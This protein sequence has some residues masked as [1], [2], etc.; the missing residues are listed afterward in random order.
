NSSVV[1]GLRVG[2]RGQSKTEE[3]EP[4]G[5]HFATNAER[6]IPTPK[7]QA[8]SGRLLSPL[9]RQPKLANATNRLVRVSR[10]PLAAGLGGY[11][12]GRRRPRGAA[13]HFNRDNRAA[14]LLRSKEAWHLVVVALPRDRLPALHSGL[15]TLTRQFGHMSHGIL[16]RVAISRQVAKVG[17]AGHES[18]IGL[19][20]DH[21]PVQGPVH[22]SSPFACKG[23]RTRN[24]PPESKSESVERFDGSGESLGGKPL[25]TEHRKRRQ[26]GKAGLALSNLRKRSAERSNNRNCRRGRGV[27]NPAGLSNLR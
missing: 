14:D 23:V 8:R 7:A 10:R 13:L 17:N 12:I 25:G 24:R 15:H 11:L 2:R 4:P 26:R 9:L 27:D 1:I 18:A 21:R 3:A 19:A 20:I 6:P 16:V 5:V 22:G